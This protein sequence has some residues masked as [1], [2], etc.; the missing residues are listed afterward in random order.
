MENLITRADSTKNWTEK[1]LKQ[2]EVLLQPNPSKFYT[3]RKFP[4]IYKVA[5]ST[6]RTGFKEDVVLKL[7]DKR[8]V[9]TCFANCCSVTLS[10]ETKS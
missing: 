7:V 10:F 3:S 2:T 5:S 6:L 9:H 1:I 8:S 4:Y